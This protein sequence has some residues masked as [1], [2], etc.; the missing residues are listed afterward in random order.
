MC[1]DLGV[2]ASVLVFRD[3]PPSN[4]FVSSAAVSRSDQYSV[5]KRRSPDASVSCPV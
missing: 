3:S 1:L 5:D 4:A 2:W